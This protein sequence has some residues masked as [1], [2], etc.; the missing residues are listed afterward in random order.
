MIAI[1]VEIKLALVTCF[2]LILIVSYIQ[3]KEKIGQELIIAF[4]FALIPS[5]YH[6]Y[7]YTTYNII[8]LDR[9]NLYPLI[10]WTAGLVL[11]REIYEKMNIKHKLLLI[12][13]IYLFILFTLEFIGF[14]L[15]GI[16][17]DSNYPS[18]LGIGILHI[19][20][21]MKIFYLTAG[22]LYLLVTDYLK[23]K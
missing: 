4:L 10:C 8:L 3:Y 14:Y 20:M 16:R 13:T 15:L 22:P 6:F 7:Q 19:S 21:P 1:Q 5:L 9:I 11:L 23:V 2:S 18:L 12:T 17:L